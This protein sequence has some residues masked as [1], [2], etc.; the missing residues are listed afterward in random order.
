[1][2][3]CMPHAD[4]PPTERSGCYRWE[5]LALLFFAFFF[6]QGDRAL[7]GVVVSE[8]KADLQLSD[9]QIG[10]VGS[11]LFFTLAMM[12]PVAGYIGDVFSKK[13]LVTGSLIF[14]STATLL[15]GQTQGLWGLVMLRSVATAGGESFY[16]PSA[17]ALLA[18]FHKRTRA[19][20]MSVHQ[21]SLYI[22]VMVSGFLGGWIAEQWGWRSAFYL[23]GGAGIVLGGV[24]VFRLK[25][26]PPEPAAGHRPAA[27]RVRLIEA[28]GVLFRTPTALLLTVAFTGDVFVNNAY[29][30]WAPAFLGEKF[31]LSL[32]IAGGYSMSYHHLAA[33]IGVLTGAW[34]SDAAVV[35]RPKFRLQV[36]CIFMLLGAPIILVFG[37]C[38]SLAATCLAMVGFGLSRGFYES[39]IH[40]GLFDVIEPR[41]RASAV[42]VM[43]MLA[44]LVG[45]ISPWMLGRL[46]DTVPDKMGLSYGFALLSVAYLIGGLAVAAAL[47]FTFHRDRIRETAPLPK[48]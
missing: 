14:W 38:A 10:V 37:L 43:I 45:S 33:M 35:R 20:A 26:A 21:C 5:L 23:F 28:L 32:P 40:A 39:N 44:F 41:Y 18:A 15:T 4:P 11:V 8:I 31:E 22:G 12:M 30:V 2:A 9:T 13:W 36:Q 48:A 19:L 27:E 42:G 34:I 25:D 1:M 16:A 3:S 24:F 7:F 47:K 29:L 6:H 17:Y 46:R